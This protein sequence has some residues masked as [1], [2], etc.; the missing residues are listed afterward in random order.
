MDKSKRGKQARKGDTKDKDEG[1]EPYSP[2]SAIESMDWEDNLDGVK[3]LLEPPSQSRKDSEDPASADKAKDD[4][5]SSSGTDDDNDE[6]KEKSKS[7]EDQ[8]SSSSSES[9]EEAKEDDEEEEEEAKDSEVV[10][11]GGRS[12]KKALY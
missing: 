6:K 3:N 9:E 12:V 4:T 1:K 8:S 11:C 2:S 5:N 10:R 7:H